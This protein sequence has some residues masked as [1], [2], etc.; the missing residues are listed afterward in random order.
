MPSLCSTPE[1]I[2]TSPGAYLLALELTHAVAVALPGRPPAS[3][4]TGLYLYCGSARGPGGLRARVARHMRR[5]KA[6]RWHIDRLTE[7]ATVH[8]AWT[9]ADRSECGLAAALAY[10]PVPIPGFGSS[11]CRTCRSHLL[12]WTGS[13]RALL[14]MHW[15]DAR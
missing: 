14:D 11:D 3:V 6:I 2:P 15:H 5:G 8:G 7:Q 12:R 13:L 9:F 10:L 1:S 4:A